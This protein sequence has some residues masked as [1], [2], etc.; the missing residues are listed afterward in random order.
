VYDYSLLEVGE[1]EEEELGGGRTEEFRLEKNVIL[2]DI[3]FLHF[4]CF[5]YLRQSLIKFS[6]SRV[7]YSKNWLAGNFRTL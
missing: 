3:N 2:K 5:C 1:S 7:K 6:L 4:L